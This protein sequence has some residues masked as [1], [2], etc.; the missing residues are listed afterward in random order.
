MFFDQ[1]KCAKGLKAVEAYRKEWNDKLGC[2]RER[3]LHDWS[4]HATK[5][6]I[7]CAEAVGRL[8]GGSGL[9]AE[10]WKK[11]RDEYIG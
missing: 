5:A 7:Y 1:A 2:Y 4:S 10:D 11:L 8:S 9:S 3:P 6:L